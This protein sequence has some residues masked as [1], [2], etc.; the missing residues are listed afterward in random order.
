M[1]LYRGGLQKNYLINALG[2]S[3]H[4]A[5]QIQY[6]TSMFAK[7]TQFSCIKLTFYDGYREMSYTAILLF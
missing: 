7:C 1:Y 6:S 3:V 2:K 4:I 5:Y